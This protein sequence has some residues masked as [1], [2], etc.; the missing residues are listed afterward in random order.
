MM[1]TRC[2]RYRYVP[3]ISNHSQTII[4]KIVSVS[5]GVSLVPIDSLGPLLA[6]PPTPAAL[7]LD[8]SSSSPCPAFLAIAKSFFSGRG[9]MSVLPDAGDITEVMD[10]T[11]IIWIP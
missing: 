10:S 3:Y 2:R 5:E 9:A 1:K 6:S 8:S 11:F 4:I 7:P